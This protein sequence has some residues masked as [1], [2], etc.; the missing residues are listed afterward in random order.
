LNDPILG[1]ELQIEDQISLR[2]RAQEQLNQKP[3][4]WVAETSEKI[5]VFADKR[6]RDLVEHLELLQIQLEIMMGLRYGYPD[7]DAV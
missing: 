4:V 1:L 6:I 3:S 7:E 5:F 2:D